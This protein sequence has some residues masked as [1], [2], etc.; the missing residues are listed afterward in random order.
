[1]K[2]S[3]LNIRQAVQSCTRRGKGLGGATLV[4]C[5]LIALFAAGGCVERTLSVTS[6]PP[7]ALVYL[8]DQE[9]G[10]TPLKR[11]FTWYGTYEVIVRKDGYRTLKTTASVIAPIYEWVPLDLLFELSPFTFKDHR[12][13]KYSLSP[14]E[15]AAQDDAGLLDRAT[16][17]RG[18]LQ[19]SRFP[20]TKSTTR[21]K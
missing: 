1:M 18:D 16:E 8:N 7:G 21:P 9:V 20:S 3:R 17:L 13:L 4:G 5:M 15:P 11:D 6:D 12:N 2:L 10:R 14:E 19:S